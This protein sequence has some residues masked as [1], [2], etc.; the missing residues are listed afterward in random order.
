MPNIIS[1]SQFT[2]KEIEKI[3]SRAV[4]MEKACQKGNIKQILKD[5]IIACIFFEPSTRTRL[6]FETA[7]LKL[8]AKVIS[9]ENA[10]ENSSA[11]K[12]ETI[13]DTTKIICSYADIFVVRHP[14]AGIPD[15]AAKVAT[16]PIINAGDGANQHPT[17]G[18]LDLYTIK[19]EHGRLNNLKIG[20][21]GDLLN[22][23]TL[24]S[25][26]PFLRLYK[27]NKFYFISPQELKL[28]R[29]FIKDLKD[30]GVT[31]EELQSLE[32]KLPELDILYMTR[33]QKERFENVADYDRVKNLFIFKKEYLKKMKKD[34]IIMHALPKINEIELE[35]DLDPRAAYFRQAQNG[36]YTRMAVLLYALGL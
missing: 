19:K 17:Q 36:L 29:E 9:A 15:A 10:M 26:V 35:V 23:R 11:Y 20:F 33:V 14:K 30:N 16:K 28:P 8:G 21:G 18:L 34:V 27:N 3:L 31:F 5:K 1:A 12:G 7:A 6:S 24:K 2:K 25:L 13:E 22:A 4:I 32:E